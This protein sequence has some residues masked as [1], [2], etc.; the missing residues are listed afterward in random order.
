M[1]KRRGNGEGSITRRKDG[2]WEARYTIHTASG[3]KRKVIYGKTRVE[4][5]EKLA[6]AISDRSSGLTFDAGNL[7]VGEFLDGWL[8]DSVRDTVRQRT[9]ERH[10]ELVR[11]HIK[12][13]LGKLKL[14]ALTPAHVQGFYR[15]RLDSG[16]SPATV[17]KI[18]VVLHKALDRAVKWNLIPR[19]A[20]EAVNAPRPAPKE[21]R[22]LS[23][24]EARRLLEFA[25]GD[26]LE[27]L[28]VLAVHT[29]A[30]QGELLG[31]KWEDVDLEGGVI[32]IRRTITRNKGRL[33]LGAP[34]TK[35][36]R[37]TVRLTETAAESLKEH[38]ER[39]L[40]EIERLGDLY[41]DQGLVFTTQV[42][43]LINPTNL[44]KRS[45][46]PLLECAGLATIRIHDLRHT[47]ATLLLS[48]NVHPKYVQELLGHA[49]V[50]MTLDTYSHVL[51]GMGHQI[52]AAMESAL[53]HGSET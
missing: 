23:P 46:A 7:M 3:P 2:R 27:A 1:A 5:A 48:R 12:P 43:T 49:T 47:C 26:R 15:D 45:F 42:G 32:R 30:R 52:T 35:G 40:T 13:A 31:L 11:L 50:A 34:K 29:G 33:L 20:T 8:K 25:H 41:Q 22:P 17:Q 38:L 37:R 44:R 24:D 39:Q 9:Y 4:V 19:N 21:M 6:K 36:S 18:H 53:V 28:Y 14:K 10:E 51:P 16:L